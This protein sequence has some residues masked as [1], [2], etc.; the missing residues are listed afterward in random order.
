MQCFI[1]GVQERDGRDRPLSAGFQELGQ[2]LSQQV[3]GQQVDDVFQPLGMTGKFYT[4][5][6][7]GGHIGHQQQLHLALI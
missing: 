6:V 2:G 7:L 1:V 4:G 3:F 5:A